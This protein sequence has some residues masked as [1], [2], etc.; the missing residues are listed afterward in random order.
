MFKADLSILK[1][2]FH[3]SALTFLL[4]LTKSNGVVTAAASYQAKKS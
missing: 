4:V 1:F 2:L 3:L